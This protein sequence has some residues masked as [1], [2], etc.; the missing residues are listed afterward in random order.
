M[1]LYEPPGGVRKDHL[2][3]MIISSGKSVLHLQITRAH[4]VRVDTRRYAWFTRANI[5]DFPFPKRVNKAATKAEAGVV[6]NQLNID[7]LLP[8]EKLQDRQQRWV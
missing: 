1:G 6:S 3:V 7:L 8:P 2:K 5:C 4:E